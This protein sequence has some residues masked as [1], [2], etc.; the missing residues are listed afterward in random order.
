MPPPSAQSLLS[1][2]P[3]TEC[4]H[5][6]GADW[7]RLR[8]CALAFA[9][10]LAFLPPTFAAFCT[11]IRAY[12]L[13]A[14]SIA[15]WYMRWWSARVAGLEV[16]GVHTQSKRVMNIRAWRLR[17]GLCSSLIPAVTCA[18]PALSGCRQTHVRTYAG[19]YRVLQAGRSFPRL[20]CAERGTKGCEQA[21]SSCDTMRWHTNPKHSA[22][23][24]L[25]LARQINWPL[26]P[27]QGFSVP[28]RRG[29]DAY[30]LL[31][32]A[33]ET[34]AGGLRRAHVS[35]PISECPLPL[36]FRSKGRPSKS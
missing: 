25:R 3:C 4:L 28:S 11:L 29:T 23:T 9:D 6:Q 36:S 16:L 24:P 34:G 27:S 22:D 7:R 30:S 33:A 15:C 14:Y 32:L 19:H 2:F 8:C 10:S 13:L 18:C 5:G 21:G 17:G 12:L 26:M 35:A 20:C 1:T 31:R